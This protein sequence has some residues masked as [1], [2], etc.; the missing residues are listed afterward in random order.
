MER[1][2]DEHHTIPHNAHL[3]HMYRVINGDAHSIQIMNYM[4]FGLQIFCL[5]ALNRRLWSAAL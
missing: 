3:P 4:P 2:T 5:L 1:Q